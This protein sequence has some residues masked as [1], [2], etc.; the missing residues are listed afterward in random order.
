[1]APGQ[2]GHLACVGEAVQGSLPSAGLHPSLGPGAS[3]FS[4][5]LIQRKTRTGNHVAMETR[6]ALADTGENKHALLGLNPHEAIGEVPVFTRKVQ[7]P[8][9][10]QDPQPQGKSGNSSPHSIPEAM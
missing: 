9:L 7:W 3:V 6:E 5:Y 1:M 4:R 10:S 2:A 8:L